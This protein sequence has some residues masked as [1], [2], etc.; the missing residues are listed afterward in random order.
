[1]TS[2][3][4]EMN[5]I[6]EFLERPPFKREPCVDSLCPDCGAEMDFEKG[7]PERHDEPGSVDS[8]W[9]NECGEFK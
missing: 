8:W 7:A 4:D 9:C 6:A 1:V 3:F 5:K 2:I